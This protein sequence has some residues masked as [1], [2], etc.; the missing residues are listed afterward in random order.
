[1]ARLI[2]FIQKTFIESGSGINILMGLW[3][4]VRISFL[5]LLFGTLLAVPLCA[6]RMT[7]RRSPLRRVLARL[8][9]GFIA[10]VRGTPV[11]MLLMVF[12]YVIFGSTRIDAVIIAIA[13]FSLNVSANVAEIMRT[14]LLSIPGGQH[15]AAHALGLS[16]FQA[17]R[18]VTLPQAGMIGLPVY[19]SAVVNLI[20]W[21]SVVGYISITDLT[22][23]I[24]FI[25]SRTMEPLLMLFVG[26]ALYLVMAY[27]A[28]GLFALISRRK[29]GISRRYDRRRRA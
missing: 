2:E 21:T 20:Q 23:A 16:G 15:D 11:L 6:L 28:Y 25:S 17:F 7:G 3:T 10:L 5:S 1:M 13:A 26:I 12:Y 19:Q 4:T 14:S 8:A 27:S 9:Q 22:R 29:F 18:C 24:N